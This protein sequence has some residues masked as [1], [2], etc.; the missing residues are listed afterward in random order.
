MK[1]GRIGILGGSFDPIH[2]GHLAIGESAAEFFRLEKVLA[3]PCALSPF[4]AQSASREAS[5]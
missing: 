5:R 3:M 1:N 2:L 4:K